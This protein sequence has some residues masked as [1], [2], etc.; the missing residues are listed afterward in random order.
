MPVLLKNLGT[1]KYVT[2]E[3]DSSSFDR[4]SIT[5]TQCNECDE[6]T[7]LHNVNTH[8]IKTKDGRCV[9]PNQNNELIVGSCVNDNNWHYESRIINDDYENEPLSDE[10]KV[11]ITFSDSRT[12]NIGDINT[13]GKNMIFNNSSDDLTNANMYYIIKNGELYNNSGTQ[14]YETP[15]KKD[16]LKDNVQIRCNLFFVIETQQG[17]KYYKLDYFKEHQLGDF[18]RDILYFTESNSLNTS[19]SPNVAITYFGRHN[20][21]EEYLNDINQ[22]NFSKAKIGAITENG[23]V[24]NGYIDTN[25]HQGG[26]IIIDSNRTKPLTI[27]RVIPKDTVFNRMLKYSYP[28]QEDDSNYINISSYM[29]PVKKIRNKND[30]LISGN[31]KDGTSVSNFTFN[32]V[33]PYTSTVE[34]FSLLEGA[35]GENT[36]VNKIDNLKN[37]LNSNVKPERILDEISVIINDIEKSNS[38]DDFAYLKPQIKDHLNIIYTCFN[39]AKNL[40]DDISMLYQ[41]MEEN[42]FKIGLNNVYGYST[43][44]SNATMT[45]NT[46]LADT[47]INGLSALNGEISAGENLLNNSFSLNIIKVNSNIIVSL[48]ELFKYFHSHYTNIQKHVNVFFDY[49]DAKEDI[50]YFNNKFITQIKVDDNIHDYN[51]EILINGFIGDKQLGTFI[52]DMTNVDT[53][54]KFFDIDFGK[55]YDQLFVKATEPMLRDFDYDRIEKILHKNFKN[56]NDRGVMHYYYDLL[57]SQKYYYENFLDKKRYLENVNNF[58]QQFPKGN[59]VEPFEIAKHYND[60]TQKNMIE[61]DEIVPEYMKRVFGK[62]LDSNATENNQKGYFF[63]LYTF[64]KQTD[65]NN[66]N[67]SL[68]YFSVNSNLYNYYENNSLI[69]EKKRKELINSFVMNYSELKNNIESNL[70]PG[71]SHT[72]S[73]PF[74]NIENFVNETNFYSS[75]PHIIPTSAYD[76]NLFNDAFKYYLDDIKGYVSLNE[77]LS[78]KFENASYSQSQSKALCEDDVGQQIEPKINMTYRCGNESTIN[79]YPGESINNFFGNNLAACAASN[80][81]FER[82]VKL[83]YNDN[84]PTKLRLVLKDNNNNGKSDYD[85]DLNSSIFPNTINDLEVFEVDGNSTELTTELTTIYND[86]GDPN[87]VNVMTYLKDITSNSTDNNGKKYLYSTPQPYFRLYIE[88]SNIKIDY[89]PVIGKKV[90]DSFSGRY[91]FINGDAKTVRLYEHGKNVGEYLNKSVYI[92]YT[93]NSHNIDPSIMDNYKTYNYKNFCYDGILNDSDNVESDEVIAGIRNGGQI[94]KLD[95]R[96]IKNVYPKLNDGCIGSDYDITLRLKK[97]VFKPEYSACITTADDVSMITIDRY[98][99]ISGGEINNDEFNEKKCGKKH[100]FSKAIANFTESRDDFRIYF[101]NM[102]EKLN[103]LN[104]S[105][106]KMLNGTQESIENIKKSIEEYEELNEKAKNNLGKKT[107][108][109]AQTEDSRIMLKHSQYS[110][111]IMGIGAIGATMMMFNYMKK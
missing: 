105:E 41:N 52:E 1:N 12:V 55:I 100:I 39:A 8:M 37:L 30:S 16:F 73:E 43:L 25:E 86:P 17:K 24:I 13:W 11:S 69:N 96:R 93:N 79:T 14:K 91:G 102:I 19:E 110:M 51:Y 45:F 35:T 99:E 107:I 56:K 10:I 67:T 63:S 29:N 31:A 34:S 44:N 109:D 68:D 72:R 62:I 82:K 9:F 76:T 104:E 28:T 70:Y 61:Y 48:I 98:N 89:K 27:F 42:Y 75:K 3:N 50:K 33:E 108:I 74:S 26:A 15:T 53:S 88:N 97:R 38:G 78:N 95:K 64:M 84:N 94:Y 18:D 54:K 111:A 20:Y 101:A 36:I 6:N 2:F 103:E 47:V 80:Y 85:I 32:L 81:Y 65:D 21:E 7:K 22:V 77:Y 83:K 66:K 23:V 4:R 58:I 40:Y 106:L 46:T 71:G 5:V 92:D 57:L 60:E 87:N 59:S 90:S 49:N